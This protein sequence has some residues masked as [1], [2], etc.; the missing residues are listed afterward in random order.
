MNAKHALEWFHS[1]DGV[2]DPLPLDL[3]VI[4]V[5]EKDRVGRSTI[6]FREFKQQ[7]DDAARVALFDIRVNTLYQMMGRE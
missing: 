7:P 6:L 5:V 2:R 4:A 1:I 3:Y